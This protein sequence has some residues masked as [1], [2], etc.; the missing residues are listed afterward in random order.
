VKLLLVLDSLLE[1]LSVERR[2]AEARGWG[3]ERWDESE[4][5]LSRADIVV[6]VR[7]TVDRGLVRKLTKCR[8]IGRFG[9][10]LDSVDVQAATD[11]QMTVVRIKDYCVPELTSHTLAVAFS[12][13]RRLNNV[14]A[15]YELLDYDWQRVSHE[16]P[17]VGRTSAMVVGLGSIGLAVARALLAMGFRVAACDPSWRDGENAARQV[18]LEVMGLEQGLT[19][20]EFVFLHT[21]L[22][23]GTRE[24]I[25][26]SRLSWMRS[27]AI[28]VNTARLDLLDQRAV[29]R[30]LEAG[31]L[32]GLALDARLGSDSPLRRF[33]ADQRVL[34]TPHIGWYSERTLMVL[35]TRAVSE[36][37]D[38]FERLQA[39]E[40]G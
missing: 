32:G 29:A 10:G 27:D 1:D 12:L 30:S 28:L 4:A 25:N 9:T 37:I 3:L 24:M 31:L 7:T 2:T 36:S 38:A 19:A 35:R 13:E 6:H 22:D 39:G 11:A 5:G 14:G 33:A 34:V 15:P 40:V 16:R 20:S 26:A 21:A 18:G 8:V 17:I 23:D